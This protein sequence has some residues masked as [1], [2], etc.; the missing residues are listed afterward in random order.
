MRILHVNKFLY[1]RGGAEGYMLD[2]AELQRARGDDV[3][4]FAMQHPD[5][6]AD[7]NADLFP[8]RMELNPPPSGVAARV[9]TSVDILYRRSARTGMEAI[10]D[11]VV[12]LVAERS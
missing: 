7:P 1:R 9:A 6:Q 3:S 11:R 4:F 8:P 5:N 10:L 2:L 12:P